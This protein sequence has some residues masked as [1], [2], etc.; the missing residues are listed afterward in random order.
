MQKIIGEITV[1]AKR[2][3]NVE[4][5]GKCSSDISEKE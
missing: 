5:V 1:K 4:A 3:E 2:K